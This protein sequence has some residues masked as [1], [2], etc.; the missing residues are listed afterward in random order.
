MI[1]KYENN[2]KYVEIEVTDDGSP[3]DEVRSELEKFVTMLG[4]DCSKRDSRSWME[5]IN[6]AK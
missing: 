2:L 3:A 4:L 1:I 6:A 5:I